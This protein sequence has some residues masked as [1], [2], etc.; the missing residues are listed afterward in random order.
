MTAYAIRSALLPGP[1]N[2]EGMFRPIKIHVPEKSLLNPKFPVAV[3]ARAATGH[4]VPSLVFGA[5][6][7]ALSERV[8]AA[9]GS[10]Q[11]SM[12]FTGHQNGERYACVL[13]FAGGLGARAS[14]DG[15]DCLSWPS[16]ISMIPVEVAERV[17]PI[18]FKHKQLL[19]DSGGQ[20]RFRGG[21]GQEAL[22]ELYGEGGASLFFMTERTC[23]AAPG[24]DGGGAGALGELLI[25]GK[26]VDSRA[27]QY[28]RQ[29]AQVLIRTPGGGGYRP[30]AQREPSAIAEDRLGGYTA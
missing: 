15:V 30:V 5:L 25:D 16:N 1:P 18:L 28:V 17:A 23:I 7:K 2:N 4:Y 27:P 13:F 10:P 14:S 26:P 11:W 22:I 19:P 24:L 21:L 3:G 29:G 9:S 12:T 8:I 20:G 6:F